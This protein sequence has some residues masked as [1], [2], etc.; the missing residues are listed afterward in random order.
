MSTGNDRTDNERLKPV[1]TANGICYC[2]QM[3]DLK[4]ALIKT[5]SEWP[6]RHGKTILQDDIAP[7]TQ[8]KRSETPFLHLI[9]KSYPARRTHRTWP[10]QNT[11]CFH[12]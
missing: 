12:P 7:Y 9:G 10:L 6:A 1:E 3:I 5:R 4:Y 2:Q 11:T 8:K